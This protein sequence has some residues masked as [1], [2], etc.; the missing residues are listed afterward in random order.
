MDVLNEHL[1]NSMPQPIIGVETDGWEWPMCDF[2]VET[3]LCRIDV[4]G[5]LQAK[6]VIEFRHFRDA[7]GNIYEP[8]DLYLEEGQ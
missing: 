5:K 3:G 1:I 8:D 7:D 4:M 2:E 6:R